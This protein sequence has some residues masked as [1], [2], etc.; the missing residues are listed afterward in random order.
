[1][2]TKIWTLNLSY[3]KGTTYPWN[4]MKDY[5]K[6]FGV[7]MKRDYTMYVGHAGINLKGGQ[8]ALTKFCREVGLAW[9]VKFPPWKEVKVTVYKKKKK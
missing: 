4:M 7:S 6:Q 1:M 8:R 2:A 5:A 9:G 3:E